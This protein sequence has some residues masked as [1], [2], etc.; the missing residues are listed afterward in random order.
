MQYPGFVGPSNQSQSPLA[1]VERLVNLYVEPNDAGSGRPALY[2]TPGASAFCAVGDVGTRALFTMNARTFGAIGGGA[3]ELFG[4]HLSTRYGSMVQDSNPAQI[5]VN[6]VAGNQALFASGGNAYLLTLNTSTWVGSVLTGAAMQIGMLDGYFLAFAN[7]KLRVSGLND[8]TTWDPTQF[9]LRSSAPDNWLAM[10]VNAPD[11]W[12]IGEQTGD[13]WFDAGTSPFPFA[14]RPGATFPFGIAAPFSLASAGDSVLWISR[15]AEGAGI[16]VRARGYVPQPIGSYAVDNALAKYQQTSTIADAEA[17]VFQRRG[18]TFYVLKFPTA[19]ATWVY[20]LRTNLWFEMGQWNPAQNR[21]DAWHPRAIT[22]A[23]GQHLVGESATSAISMLDDS[24]GT[25]ADGSAI[26]RLRIPSALPAV[27]GGRIFV[28]RFEL[29]IEPGVGTVAGQGANPVA[30]MR[31]SKDYA[32]TWGSELSRAIGRSGE[33][34]KRVFWTRCGSSP[35]SWVPEIV[36][37]DPVP[38]KIVSATVIGRGIGAG[39]K[40]A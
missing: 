8:G 3:Y 7:A 15:N 19:N 17:L 29:G 13:V 10:T 11:I 5:M 23:F 22:Y 24:V 14:P 35:I 37:T 39:Q 38:V 18:H 16:V 12:L 34:H 2:S 21:Y 1:D 28:D 4:T 26:R 25:E 31:I 33:T 36:I 32:K 20:D 9:A 27:D 6:G 30:M 40:A